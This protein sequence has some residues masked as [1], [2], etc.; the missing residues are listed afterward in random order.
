MLAYQN[1]FCLSNTVT[2]NQ[3]IFREVNLPVKQAIALC[4][5]VFL[6]LIRINYYEYYSTQQCTLNYTNTERTTSDFN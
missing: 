4:I 1:S 6:F 5:F 2:T 3:F